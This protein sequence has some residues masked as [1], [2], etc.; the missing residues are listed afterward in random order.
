MGSL[1]EHLFLQLSRDGGKQEHWAQIDAEK[2]V[3]SL[4]FVVLP[5]RATLVLSRDDEGHLQRQP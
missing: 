3:P 1:F 5:W 2:N 4:H